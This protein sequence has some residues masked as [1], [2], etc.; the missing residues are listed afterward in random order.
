MGISFTLIVSTHLDDDDS[1]SDCQ[2]SLPVRKIDK[3]RSFAICMPFKIV[4]ASLGFLTNIKLAYHHASFYEHA[5]A[6]REFL[7]RKP[8]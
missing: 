4:D 3:Q 7:P 8:G 2:L 6:K 5:L 1:A